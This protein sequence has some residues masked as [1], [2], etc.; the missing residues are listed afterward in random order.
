M[1]RRRLLRNPVA[2]ALV[3]SFAAL[4]AV[5]VSDPAGLLPGTSSDRRPS[6]P[7]APPD[8]AVWGL[9]P[10]GVEALPQDGTPTLFVA[11]GG[12]GPCEEEAPCGSI[13]D[14]YQRA[15][16]GEVVELAPGRYPHQRVQHRP[17]AAVFPTNVVVRPPRAGAAT[18]DGALVLA[19]RLTL[20]GVRSTGPIG[21]RKEA[22]YSR[23]E[24]IV[25]EGDVKRRKESWAGSAVG[26]GAD[27]TALVDSVL[28]GNVDQDLLKVQM[29]AT[30]VLVEGNRIGGADKG[31]LA[32]HVDCIQVQGAHRVVIRRNI[33][34]RCSNSALFISSHVGPISDVLVESNFIQDCLVR[35]DGCRG[36]FAVYLQRDKA[37]ANDTVGLRFLHNT[38]DGRIRLAPDIP[39]LEM[40]GNII[41]QLDEC[42]SFEDWNL[43][44]TTRCPRLSPNDR[45]GKPVY[46]DRERVD[47]RL[48]AGS[49]GLGF[50]VPGPPPPDIAGERSL[51]RGNAGAHQGQGL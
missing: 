18:I 49:P 10:G 24:S 50:G 31:P 45:R 12:K 3:L 19:S 23:L 21:L 37:G 13:D 40:R 16:P 34:Y 1:R 15:R 32:G 17:D 36:A 25:I 42:G 29:G 14:A 26:L 47:L 44:E 4:V 43:V 5:A 22:A 27:H 8:A 2:V 39:G 33:I 7:A 38:V 6:S 9:G 28:T 35:T 41:R 51:G 48:R 11:P 20:R 30:D 46:V